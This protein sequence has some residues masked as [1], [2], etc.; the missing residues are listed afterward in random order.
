MLKGYMVRERLG[1][2]GPHDSLQTYIRAIG[3]CSGCVWERS[4]LFFTGL[5]LRCFDFTFKCFGDFV[6][7]LDIIKG[8]NQTLSA[9]GELL[10][11]K[12]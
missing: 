4:T 6:V 2:P 11:D 12:W 3:R 8:G 5:T 1:T 10:T 9:T 7:Y